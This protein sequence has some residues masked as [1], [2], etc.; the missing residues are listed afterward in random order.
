MMCYE[1]S[2]TTMR[3]TQP[4]DLAM[5]NRWAILRTCAMYAPYESKI[6]IIQRDH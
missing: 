1:V 4:K 3:Q 5:V 2:L 6:G